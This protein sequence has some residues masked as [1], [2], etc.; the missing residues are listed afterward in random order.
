VV[1]DGIADGRFSP[2]SLL[3]LFAVVAASSLSPRGIIQS[4][5]LAPVTTATATATALS[6]AQAPGRASAPGEQQQQRCRRKTQDAE[7]QRRNSILLPRA[8]IVQAPSMSQSPRGW[9]ETE[10]FLFCSVLFCSVLAGANM[11]TPVPHESS[12]PR[13]PPPL[14]PARTCQTTLVRPSRESSHPPLHSTASSSLPSRAE[15]QSPPKGPPPL[16]ALSGPELFG[17][18][19]ITRPPPSSGAFA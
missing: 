6:P 15:R 2:P 7:T 16:I 12:G 1:W 3:Q 4:K 11:N 18:A 9:R 19:A 17:H 8:V 14:R 13:L 5:R 10:A